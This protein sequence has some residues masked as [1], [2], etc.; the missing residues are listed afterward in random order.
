MLY[1]TGLPYLGLGPSAHSYDGS[2]RNWNNCSLKA[3]LDPE[4]TLEGLMESEHL[5]KKERYHDYL[6]TSLRTRW[7]A[8][9]EYIENVFGKDFRFYFEERA[10]A[11]INAGT[12]ALAEGR[13]F[14]DPDN[15][16]MTD[17]ILRSLFKD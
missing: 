4:S 17:Y 12:I 3:Y 10:K 7:G 14:I 6:I 9:P 16:L 15:W 1:W 11:F 2:N 5:S 13:L 8:D